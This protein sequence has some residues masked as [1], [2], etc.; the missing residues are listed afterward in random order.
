MIGCDIIEIQRIQNAFL[1]RGDRFAQRILTPNEMELFL[2]HNKRISFLAGRFAAKE[3]IAKTLQTGFTNGVTFHS[4]EILPV[5]PVP[6]TPV[7]VALVPVAPQVT[8]VPATPV[9]ATPVPATP[10]PVAL[11]PVAPQVTLNLSPKTEALILS[12]LMAMPS[13]AH[14][15]HN[16]HLRRHSASGAGAKIVVDVSISHCR[17]YAVAVSRA[18]VIA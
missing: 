5:A 2:K 15:G 6:A 11:V 18:T 7:P 13:N 3:S 10:V 8:L 9:P 16:E 12:R 14:N 1:K 17:T 4:M